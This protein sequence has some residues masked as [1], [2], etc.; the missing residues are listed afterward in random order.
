MNG[1][2]KTALLAAAMALPASPAWAQQAQGFD[3]RSL[4][5]ENF[6]G[7]IEIRNGERLSVSAEPGRGGH[8]APS[9]REEAGGVMIDGG[10]SLDNVRCSRRGGELTFTTERSGFFGFMRRGG[11][12]GRLSDYPVLVIS[13]PEDIALSIRSSIYDGSAGSLGSA[14]IQVRGCGRFEMLDVAGDA[15]LRVSGSG[16]LK[17]GDIG[18]DAVLRISGSGR[19]EAGNVGGDAEL[20]ISGSGSVSAGDIGGA[21]QMR[22]SGS[23]SLSAGDVHDVEIRVSGSGSV[24]MQNQTGAFSARLSGS[25]GVQVGAGRAE[26]FEVR[27]SGS[28]GVR[29]GGEAV[30]ADVS[31]S[32]SGTVSAERFSGS[33]NW[34]GRGA[35]RM[36][37]TGE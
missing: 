34:R 14:D 10:Y 4:S 21:S 31:V 30:N 20:R 1:V 3:A 35:T 16:R 12:S 27:I 33:M 11:E 29:H 2:F 19:V 26:P 36:Q 7:R 24:Q 25:G 23:G 32:G 6:I 37:S 13:A 15:G 18:G 22:I 17:A 28:G 9:I 5:I 8:E